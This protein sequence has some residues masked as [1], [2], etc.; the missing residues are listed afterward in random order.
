[1][2]QFNFVS[3]LTLM[4]VVTTTSFSM[5]WLP[6]PSR[7]SSFSSHLVMSKDVIGR[8]R[9]QRRGRGATE[10]GNDDDDDTRNMDI[11][12]PGDLQR[13]LRGNGIFSPQ[14][15]NK[16]GRQ[17]TNPKTVW[18]EE[19]VEKLR[20]IALQGNENNIDVNNQDNK[21]AA[22]A[23]SQAF[24]DEFKDYEDDDDKPYLDETTYLESSRNIRPDGSIRIPVQDKNEQ[25]QEE[26]LFGENLYTEAVIESF[27]PSKNYPRNNNSNNVSSSSSNA[28]RPPTAPPA[29][30]ATMDDLIKAQNRYRN[31]NPEERQRQGDEL[32]RKVF[33][34]ERAYQDNSEDFK[35]GLTDKA[36]AQEAQTKRRSSRFQQKQEKAAEELQEAVEDWLEDFDKVQIMLMEQRALEEKKKK[37]QQ[38]KEKSKRQ[39]QQQ[40]VDEEGEE[41]Q[42]ADQQTLNGDDSTVSDNFLES[43]ATAQRQAA[44][45]SSARRDKSPSMQQ[46][47]SRAAPGAASSSS[48]NTNV[49]FPNQSK[50]TKADIEQF[51]RDFMSTSGGGGATTPAGAILVQ[52]RKQQE[53]QRQQ[54]EMNQQRGGQTVSNGSESRNFKGTG[55][56]KV[57]NDEK[58]GDSQW[59]LV[60][61]PS[62]GEPFYW[63]SETGEMKSEL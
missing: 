35:F 23:T 27:Q 22:S 40:Q 62:T 36:K 20:Q 6:F 41:D 60:D 59:E 58:N 29:P 15:P 37:Q 26:G 50:P 13:A 5:A 49:S 7:I 32:K 43:S 19:S 1:M 8:R 46:S 33:E 30:A 12:S 28:K 21:Q 11:Q 38:Q 17:R 48:P 45:F 55:T 31:M 18:N 16:T 51:R 10:G 53:Q 9:Q 39:N 47:K 34:N 3:Y 52:R 2:M 56:A 54:S 42:D 25:P 57:A 24:L 63:N 4:A 61:D 44:T 14:S